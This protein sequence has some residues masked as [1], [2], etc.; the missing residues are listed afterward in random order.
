MIRNADVH[1]MKQE[2]AFS[3]VVPFFNEKESAVEVCLE[4]KSVLQ[5]RGPESE[6]I[7]VDDGSNDGTGDILDRVATSWP[8]C[9]VFHLAENQGQAAALS[10]GFDK[11]SAP[12][13][14]TMDG[15]GQ[16]DPRDIPEITRAAGGG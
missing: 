12:V 2:P 4:L 11:V 14:V 7:L 6:V 9:R 10:F 3:L 13:V 8:R 5:A 16:N 1:F 15:D